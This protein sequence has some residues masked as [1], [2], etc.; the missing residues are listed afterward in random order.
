VGEYTA[1]SSGVTIF[2]NMAGR[3]P[4]FEASMTSPENRE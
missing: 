1:R 3:T 4:R 2:G